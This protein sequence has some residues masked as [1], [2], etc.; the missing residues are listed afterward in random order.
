MRGTMLCIWYCDA[1]IYLAQG[2]SLLEGV[3]LLEKVCH[4]GY[5]FYDPRLSSLEASLLLSAFAWRCRTLSSSSP[6]FAWMLP[7]SH[8]DNGLNFWAC[9]PAPFK[10][11]TYKSSLDPGGFLSLR[12]AWYTEWVPG[13]PGLYRE[14][15]SQKSKAKQNKTNKQTN[16]K[17]CLDHGVSSQH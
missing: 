15:L 9:N 3:T 7:S 13:Q 2:V 6:M 12:P 11:C 1:W 5:G 16:K 8:F 17:S 4:C 10:C 14:T